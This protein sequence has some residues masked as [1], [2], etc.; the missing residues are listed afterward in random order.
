MTSFVKERCFPGRWSLQHQRRSIWRGSSL[1][2][3][4]LIAKFQT[5]VA[6]QP[7][8]S[9]P[10][11]SEACLPGMWWCS[12]APVPSLSGFSHFHLVPEKPVRKWERNF[13]FHPAKAG[14]T[15]VVFSHPIIVYDYKIGI[16]I[17]I[18]IIGIFFLTEF[19][20]HSMLE[21]KVPIFRILET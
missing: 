2:S 19:F 16:D 1:P 17:K 11:L 4:L 5:P 14:R 13:Q 10:H 9:S 18:P 8:L 12:Q 20:T 3:S 7:Y 15:W 6:S 21:V